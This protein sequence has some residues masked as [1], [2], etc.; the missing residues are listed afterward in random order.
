VGAAA[1]DGDDD[2][3]D[4]WWDRDLIGL[5]AVT[6]DGVDLGVVVDVLHTP[7]GELLA[8]GRTDGPDVLIPFV[9]AIVPNV[10]VAHGRLVVDP[11]SGLVDLE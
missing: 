8:V 2:G 7:A 9:R 6:V 3:D 1:D 4:L 5:R 10:E 11:P